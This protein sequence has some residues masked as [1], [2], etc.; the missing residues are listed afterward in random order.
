[1]STNAEPEERPDKAETA[2]ERQTG[3][4]DTAQVA[5]RKRRMI[6]HHYIRVV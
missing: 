3:R 1:M 5:S 2:Q 4:T 6:N